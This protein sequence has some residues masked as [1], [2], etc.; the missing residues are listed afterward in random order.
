MLNG[1]TAQKILGVIGPVAKPS[2]YL[3]G[4]HNMFP[5]MMLMDLMLN[6]MGKRVGVM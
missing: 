5:Q 4:Q 3:P 1:G 2:E 6:I